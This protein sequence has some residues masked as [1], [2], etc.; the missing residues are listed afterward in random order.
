M[1]NLENKSKSIKKT[2]DSAAQ[3]LMN[4]LENDIGRNF[5]IES[6]FLE[7]LDN[8]DWHWVI[9]EFLKAD[10]IPP[11]ISHPNYYWYKNKRKFLSLWAVVKT[12]RSS[13]FKADLILVNYADDKNL[14]IKEMLVQEIDMNPHD[15]YREAKVDKDGNIIKKAIPNHIKTTNIELS[16]EEWK[17]KFKNFNK[18]KKG[19]TWE[20]L[21]ILRDEDISNDVL[22]TSPQGKYKDTPIS[23]IDCEDLMTLATHG[24][25]KYISI[26]REKFIKLCKKI[27]TQTN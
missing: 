2:D 22:I 7:K 27:K 3:L 19:D 1:N 6:I 8:G 21:D 9:F 11:Q 14:G 16:F 12:F 24:K 20:I 4:V 15:N 17:Q 18:N 23:E 10:T 13:G 26:A 25:S 5:D